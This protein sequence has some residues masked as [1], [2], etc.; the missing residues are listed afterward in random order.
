MLL[1]PANLAFTQSHA[2]GALMPHALTE[3]N[4]A[5]VTRPAS[6][7]NGLALSRFSVI[8]ATPPC[9]IT[10]RSPVQGSCAVQEHLCLTRPYVS[11]ARTLASRLLKRGNEVQALI[12]LVADPAVG[13][14]KDICG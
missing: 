3:L 8:Y 1:G 9:V 2:S 13:G 12:A 14:R 10:Q 5:E 11:K 4:L 7:L 6:R